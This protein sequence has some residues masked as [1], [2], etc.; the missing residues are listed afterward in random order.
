MYTDRAGFQSASRESPEHRDM[1]K[2]EQIYKKEEKTPN[3]ASTLPLARAAT[4]DGRQKDRTPPWLDDGCKLPTKYGWVVRWRGF[5]P[6]SFR[7]Y[8]SRLVVWLGWRLVSDPH[9]S[10]PSTYVVNIESGSLLSH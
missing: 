3:A 8:G 4:E 1:N 6:L 10:F 7:S 2:K 5:I 9:R